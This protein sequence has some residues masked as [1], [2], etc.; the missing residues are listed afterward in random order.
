MCLFVFSLES[1]PVQAVPPE[2][3][4]NDVIWVSAVTS[5]VGA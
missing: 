2:R 5:R 1:S 4:A 3:T